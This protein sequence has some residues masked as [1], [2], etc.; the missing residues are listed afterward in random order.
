MPDKSHRNPR[1]YCCCC[2]A[3]PA[4]DA[5]SFSRSIA[6]P[7]DGAL[8]LHPACTNGQSNRS[9]QNDTLYFR[10]QTLDTKA[11]S[12]PMHRTVARPAS[13]FLSL[14]VQYMQARAKHV[15]CLLVNAFKSP[16]RI[17]SPVVHTNVRCCGCRG[18]R[19]ECK[20]CKPTLNMCHACSARQPVASSQC[21]NIM[22]SS[23]TMTLRLLLVRARFFLSKRKASLHL[24]GGAEKG[25][26]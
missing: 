26:G 6:H 4:V 5:V 16:L 23:V 1:A 19:Y 3:A 9:T 22:F 20:S 12:S 17:S 13:R 18:P 10:T 15:S 25:M 14:R 8:P 7:C 2:W 11:P 21:F 24:V